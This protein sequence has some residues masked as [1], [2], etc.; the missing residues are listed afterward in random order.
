MNKEQKGAIASGLKVSGFRDYIA[1][2]LLIRNNMLEQGA[3]L[4]SI[5]V[6]KYIKACL[7]YFDSQ[8]KVH[9]NHQNFIPF[10][11]RVSPTI[12]DK[13]NIEFI[14][15]LGLIY[16]CR[17]YSNHEKEI[18][19]GIHKWKFLAELDYTMNLLD[20]KTTLTRQDGSS[21]SVFKQAVEN[22]DES[23]MGECYL[24]MRVEKKKFVERYTHAVAMLFNPS[25]TG[26]VQVNYGRCLTLDTDSF[27]PENLF[28]RN[29]DSDS[30]TLN[31]EVFRPHP[32]DIENLLIKSK[33]PST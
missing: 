17:Y 28:I 3:I 18:S 6:E 2:R 7:V 27:L 14:R 26:P 19:I 9:L 13:I 32:E 30:F 24:A 20:G 12:L 33:A 5:A 8:K 22:L 23:V 16:Q 29:G 15:Y 25:G 21:D 4:A 31:M 1:S 11:N 10:I